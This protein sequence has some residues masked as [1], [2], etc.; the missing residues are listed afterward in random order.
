M[1]PLMRAQVLLLLVVLLGWAQMLMVLVLVPELIL[2]VQGLALMLAV[3]PVLS[4][5]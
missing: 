4:V 1:A 2:L 5:L 3:L